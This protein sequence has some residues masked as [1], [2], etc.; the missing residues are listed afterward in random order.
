MINIS[1]SEY[2]Q[3]FLIYL[4]SNKKLIGLIKLQE[5]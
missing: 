5:I 1:N 2:I 3:I 4:K